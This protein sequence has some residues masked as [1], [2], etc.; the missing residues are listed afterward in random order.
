MKTTWPILRRY[1]AEHLDRVALPLGGIGTGT[2]SLGGRGDL[3]DWE[4]MNTPRKGF[5]PGVDSG[6]QPHPSAVLWYR[7]GRNAPVT[8]L[9]EGPVPLD[10]YEGYRGAETANHGLPRF[11]QAEFRTAY[12]LAE[13][14]L[15]DRAV[16]LRVTLQAFNP[17]V[18]GDVDASSWPLA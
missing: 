4:V 17:L 10:E 2:V 13:I 18:P 5:V 1:D 15:R 9:L 7:V 6:M 16:P 3:R 8:R 12:P 14:R 11:S